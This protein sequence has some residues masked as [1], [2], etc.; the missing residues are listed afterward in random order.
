M[1]VR[2]PPP[3]VLA[4]LWHSSRGD[5]TLA[6]PFAFG[7]FRL[8]NIATSLNPTGNFPVKQKRA[9]SSNPNRA[10]SPD[11][12]R[13]AHQKAIETVPTAAASSH[14]RLPRRSA[15]LLMASHVMA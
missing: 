8:R 6:F 2:F 12:L 15:V 10:I 7:S 9:T 14:G 3:K 4:A 1:R 13:R 11:F 5:A